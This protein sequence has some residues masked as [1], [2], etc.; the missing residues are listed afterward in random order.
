MPLDGHATMDAWA[1][2]RAV[3]DDDGDEVGDGAASAA[4][5]GQTDDA[6]A[7]TCCGQPSCTIITPAMHP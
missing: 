3:I 4:L 6:V 1:T 2:A 7:T 5:V